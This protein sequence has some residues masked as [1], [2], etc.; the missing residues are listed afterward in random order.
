MAHNSVEFED[1]LPLMAEKLGEEGLMEELCNGFRLLMDPRRKL[2]TFESLKR[3]A[4]LLGLEGLRDD[5]LRGMLREGDLDGDGALS[6]MEFCVLM[7]RLSPELM[8]QS[9]PLLDEAF[10]QAIGG[11]L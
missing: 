9:R 5:E 6:E 11:G 10:R 3:H 7:V 8:E 4:A 1:F 2:I